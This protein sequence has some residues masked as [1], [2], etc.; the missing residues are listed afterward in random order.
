MNNHSFPLAYR[1]LQSNLCVNEELH[2][3]VRSHAHQCCTQMKDVTRSKKTDWLMICVACGSLNSRKTQPHIHAVTIANAFWCVTFLVLERQECFFFHRKICDCAF[4]FGRT[5]IIIHR[6]RNSVVWKVSGVVLHANV[7]STSGQ[8]TGKHFCERRR[9]RMVWV[10]HEH[11]ST[12]T[13]V[14]KSTVQFTSENKCMQN[15]API[16]LLWMVFVMSVI[17]ILF[18]V[19]FFHRG[20]NTRETLFLHIIKKCLTYISAKCRFDRQENIKSHFF[21]KFVNGTGFFFHCQFL[22]F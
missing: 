9:I 19:F 8:K 22:Y 12:H 3:C 5:K 16:Q 14:P 18:Y 15:V 20:K 13:H 11:Q 17:Q 6:L 4:F 1:S 7:H 21:T 10:A 2:V